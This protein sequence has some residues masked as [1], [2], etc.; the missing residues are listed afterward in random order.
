ME[1]EKMTVT[2]TSNKLRACMNCGIIKPGSYFKDNGCP[3]CPFL[4]V[5]KNKNFSEV[6]SSS[7]KGSIGLVDPKKS[8]VAKWH[9]LDGYV[10]GSYAMIV[11]GELREMFIER[12]EQE[13]RVY[14]DRSKPF[15]LQ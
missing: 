15:D 1:T 14:F 12:I 9:R 8:W 3:N 13:G 7:F 6:T 11:E 4:Q 10:P 2:G 5:N